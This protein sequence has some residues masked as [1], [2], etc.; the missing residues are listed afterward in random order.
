MIPRLAVALIGLV[1]TWTA[2][3]S[4]A[5]AQ[6]CPTVNC[7]PPPIPPPGNF[8]DGKNRYI[9]SL[10]AREDPRLGSTAIQTD[11]TKFDLANPKPAA[12][13]CDIVPNQDRRLQ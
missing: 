10:R 1:L 4:S 3:P 11:C 2:L 7:L 6:S 9:G 12:R 5:H 8:V 13:N